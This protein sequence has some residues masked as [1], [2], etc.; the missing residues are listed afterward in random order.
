M[1]IIL[2]LCLLAA[3]SIPSFAQEGLDLP[4]EP[5]VWTGLK[6]DERPP[7]IED[8][9]GDD[10]RDTPP[11][12]FFG[13]ELDFSKNSVVYVLD[14]SCSMNT[15]EPNPFEFYDGTIVTGTRRARALSETIKSINT[16]TPD[17][18]FSVI[19]YG[20]AG[21]AW[22]IPLVKATR[23]NKVAAL[24]FLSLFSN[25][26]LGDTA[27]GPYT[28]YGIQLDNSNKHVVL[29][30]DGKPNFDMPGG[31]VQNPEWHRSLIRNRNNGSRVDVFGIQVNGD[32]RAFCQGV[33]RDN[34][35]RFYDIQ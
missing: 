26:C 6:A 3:L 32:A 19:V 35:G 9:A 14:L 34:G 18:K 7:E 22:Q 13:E 31:S 12:T 17:K 33:A 2:A 30:T 5:P 15:I 16:L 29:L 23:E 4:I 27:T 11:P 1:R 8:E 10:P 20:T 21:I 24:L 28:V 25:Q